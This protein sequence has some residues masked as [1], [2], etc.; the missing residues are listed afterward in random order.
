MQYCD[1]KSYLC[2]DI[3]V[4]VDRASMAHSLEVRC[5]LLDHRIIELA[6]RM[7]LAH[8]A[9]QGVARLHSRRPLPLGLSRHSSNVTSRASLSPCAPGCK[10]LW[11]RA[12]SRLC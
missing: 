10:G 4:R 1:I 5:P 7:P 12:S 11:P 8:K 9:D 2:D 3:L 6:A